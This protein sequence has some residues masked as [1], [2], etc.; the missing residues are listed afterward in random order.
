MAA[1]GVELKR[2]G[3]AENPRIHPLADVKSDQI[4]EGTNIWQF[5]VIFEGAKIGADCNI[6]AHV[7]VES[8]VVIGDRV[9]VK[10][11]VQLWD[12]L[13]VDEDVFIGPNATF[14]N[15]IFP[16][17]KNH[18]NA[19]L[20]T[21]VYRGASIGA[22]AVILPGVE[23]GPYSMIGAGSVVTRSVPAN[24][25]VVGNPA[26]IIGNV[27]GRVRSNVDGTPT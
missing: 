27:S 18:E 4:G 6:C 10:S 2:V 17:S 26:R 24:A 12:G 22:G 7:L 20:V 25:V 21:R 13:R 5:V 16:R 23:I 8:D 15:D 9:T 1:H 11:G 14:A 19:L 3:E